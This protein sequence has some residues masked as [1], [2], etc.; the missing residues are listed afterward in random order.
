MAH[1]KESTPVQVI[2]AAPETASDHALL[3]RFRRGNE[4]AATQIYLRY[5]NRLRGLAQ[6]QMSPDLARRVEIDDIVQSVFR[7]FFR[8]ASTGYYNVPAGEEL[9]KLFLVIALHKIR[10]QGN[11]HHA[12]KRDIRRTA[13]SSH[14]EQ[15]ID[16]KAEGDSAAFAFLQLVIDEALERLS[17][18][19]REMVQLRIEGYE[20]IEI[21][22]KTG[23]SKRTVERILQ[24]ARRKL[25]DLLEEGK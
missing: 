9:W 17:P 13:D 2:P 20:V 1:N 15:R 12:A 8:R 6:A 11:F 24:E 10:N 16:A 25:K 14:L 4:D 21:A 7:S 3:Q 23:R 22:R 5:A 19:H 18:Q